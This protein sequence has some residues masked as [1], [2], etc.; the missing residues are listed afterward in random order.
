MRTATSSQKPARSQGA[1]QDPSPP[2]S[3][4][5]GQRCGKHAKARQPQVRSLPV[6]HPNAAGIDA[7]ATQMYVAPPPGRGAAAVEV[8]DTFTEDLERLARWLVALGVDTVAI[9]STGVYW[10]P[11]FQILEA[12][13]IEVCLVNPQHVKHVPGRKTDCADC[14]WLQY[15][16][17]VGLLNPSFRPPESICAVRSLL[18]HRGTLVAEGARQIQRIQKALTEMNLQIHHVLSDISGLSG[19]RILAAILA[20]ERDP[21]KLAALRDRK[22]KAT[23]ETVVKALRG[24][25]SPAQ[26]FVLRQAVENYRF[27]QQQMQECDREIERML[28]QFDSQA[29]PAQA[30]PPPKNGPVGK[31]RKNQVQFQETDLRKE[32]FRLYG[33][34]LTQQ[35][36]LGPAIVLGLY[37]ELGAELAEAFPTSKRFTNW[38]G[39]CPNPKVSGGK[40]L[41]R[42]T[43]GV[44][45]RVAQLFRLAAQSLHASQGELGQYL[46][47]MQARLGKAEGITATAHKLARVFYHLVTTKEPYDGTHFARQREARLKRRLRRLRQDANTLGFV[48]AAAPAVS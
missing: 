29:D 16:H 46:R 24:T 38:M 1:T 23:E 43:R 36:G 31:S 2:T 41:Y 26:L 25:W 39:I 10:I 35:E 40:V 12:H 11:L 18:R 6:L 5:H 32:L 17:S 3:A 19:M 44:K 27:F 34:D 15:L 7:G 28:Q 42:G 45:H 48:L 22:V 8:F 33:T 4:P 14:Q 9:E 37:A 13:H 30:P 47:Y 20:G 21:E